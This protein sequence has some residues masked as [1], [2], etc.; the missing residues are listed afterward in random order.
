MLGDYQ[1]YCPLHFYAE[2]AALS[3]ANSVSAYIIT[4]PSTQHFSSFLFDYDRNTFD[5]LGPCHADVS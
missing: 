3:N 5:W 1:F 4:Q 2:S